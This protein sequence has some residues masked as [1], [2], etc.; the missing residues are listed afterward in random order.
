MRDQDRQFLVPLARRVLAA[1]HRLLS[2]FYITIRRAASVHIGA[3][4]LVLVSASSAKLRKTASAHLGAAC[5]A[6]KAQ[7]AVVWPKMRSTLHF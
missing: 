7:H 3:A 5:Y 1:A 6:V 2:W 4:R